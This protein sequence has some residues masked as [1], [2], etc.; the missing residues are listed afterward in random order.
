MTLPDTRGTR[1]FDKFAEDQFGN[2]TLN[3]L[4]PSRTAGT[5][6]EYLSRI[7][8]TAGDGTGTKVAIGD[9]SDGGVIF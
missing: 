4:D 7:L 2:T 5:Q 1:E 9:Y 8:D 6:K 3:I